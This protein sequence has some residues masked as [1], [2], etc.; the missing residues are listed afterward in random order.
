MALVAL[1]EAIE[2]RPNYAEAWFYGGRA[3]KA[4]GRLDEAELY[5]R[6]LLELEPGH[7]RGYVAIAEVLD[8]LGR[9]EEA[10]RFRRHG[11]NYLGSTDSSD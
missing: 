3:L 11:M 2:L 5:Y 9:G 4:L 6:R 10:L 8:E 1:G 7:A